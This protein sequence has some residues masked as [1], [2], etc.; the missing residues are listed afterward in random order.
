MSDPHGDTS[1]TGSVPKLYERYL[2][3]LIFQPYVADLVGRLPR[4]GIAR[5]LEIASGTGVLTRELA[6]ALPESVAIVATDL[7]EA[8]LEYGEEL[9][10]TRPV[11]W[12]QADAGTLPFPDESFD[13]VVCQF[14]VMFF[15]DKAKAF[16]EARRVLRP[17]GVFLFNTW[18]RIEENEF[19]DTVTN[20]LESLFP[21]DPPRFHAR[22]PHGYSD[23]ATIEGDM[24]AGG[25][26]KP[27]I[28][29]VAKE[30]RGRSA[31]EVG[32]A[33]CQGTPLRTEIEERDATLL[34][35]ATVVAVEAL[36][37]RF[38]KDKPIGKIQAHVV[39]AT[40]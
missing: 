37:E 13:A 29:T 14:G 38:G 8:M 35:N 23:R 26:G 24:M 36:T 4:N 19:V 10:T 27:E 18:D 9:G 31:R 5:V 39:K 20:A 7:N 6:G 30:S 3:P 28:T 2:V 12:R 34:G 40:K 33:Y 21:D 32:I 11:E 16:A 17:G 22:V 1:F 15:P 25:F